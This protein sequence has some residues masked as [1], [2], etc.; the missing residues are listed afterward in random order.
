[1]VMKTIIRNEDPYI[2]A[3]L[4]V[5]LLST[6]LLRDYELYEDGLY[7]F[8]SQKIN[9]LR[10]MIKTFLAALYEITD[11]QFYFEVINDQEAILKIYGGNGLFSY[12]VLFNSA[13]THGRNQ[14]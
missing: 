1:M 6:V 14:S 2:N 11:K 4:L 12:D 10:V 9:L 3:A 8:F 7:C 13:S 5:T